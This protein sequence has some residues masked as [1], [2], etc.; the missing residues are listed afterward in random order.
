MN[1][2]I[3]RH[4][5]QKYSQSD[6]KLYRASECFASMVFALTAPIDGFVL[7]RLAVGICVLG[8]NV[9]CESDDVRR[10]ER[11]DRAHQ[12]V[13]V[14]SPES[15]KR[16]LEVLE[17][18]VTTRMTTFSWIHAKIDGAELQKSG[19]E[20][21]LL[22]KISQHTD[23][24]VMLSDPP[25]CRLPELL[26]SIEDIQVS[27]AAQ[28]M[29]LSRM[30]NVP[31]ALS[32]MD[33]TRICSVYSVQ[34]LRIDGYRAFLRRWTKTDLSPDQRDTI[35]NCILLLDLAE[36]STRKLIRLLLP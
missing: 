23:A 21:K 31:G 25:V 34:L 28:H 30:I 9:G 29:L 10:K 12:S 6:L 36:N 20:T 18:A 27:T 35:R 26:T 7:R 22:V 32:D 16:F 2:R 24:H 33:Q 3:D 5:T 11:L 1:Q 4:Q 14:L 17:S 15:R 19:E 13:K 8:W